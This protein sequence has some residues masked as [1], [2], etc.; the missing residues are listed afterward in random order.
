MFSIGLGTGDEGDE[1]NE[2]DEGDED[3]LSLIT[4][5]SAASALKKIILYLS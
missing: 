2:G 1:G 4:H 5:E 3:K